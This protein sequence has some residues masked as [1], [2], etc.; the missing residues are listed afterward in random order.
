MKLEPTEA[1]LEAV[2]RAWAEADGPE[3]D[4]R[5]AWNVIAPMVI[6]AAASLIYEHYLTHSLE[7]EIAEDIA[8]RI[9]ELAKGE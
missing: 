1:Q 8:Q 7:D 3:G 9:R 4:A 2:R 5:I 6:E